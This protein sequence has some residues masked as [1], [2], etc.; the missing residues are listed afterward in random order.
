MDTGAVG[1]M[2]VAS[3]GPVLILGANSAIA[4]AY[5]RLC[6]G[7]GRGLVL[8]GRNR[9]RLEA[10]AAD[11]K[12]R[13][14]ASVAADVCD[15]ALLEGISDAWLEIVAAQG[16]PSEVLLAYGILGD[17][18]RTKAEPDLLQRH[19]ETNFVSAALWLECAANALETA[20]RGRLVVLGPGPTIPMVRRR[21]RSSAM[22]RA[23]RIALPV[24]AEGSPST[25]PSR[26][27]SIRR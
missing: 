15:L 4:E 7:E 17:L 9:Q 16:T 8:A 20:G 18:D 27:S 22:R 6:A 25:L 19:L 14:A 21:L 3:E 13:G 10:A 11:L 1:Q 5:A 23:S 24:P 26:V 12:A 2:T